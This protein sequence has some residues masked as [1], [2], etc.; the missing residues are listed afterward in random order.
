MKKILVVALTLIVCTGA[1]SQNDTIQ[2]PYL[3][4][5]VFPP[6]KL[7]LADSASYFTKDMLP[8]KKAIL[9]VVFNPECDHCQHETEEILKNID[10]FKDVQIVMSTNAEFRLMR[11]FI[12]HYN[13]N[14]YKNIVVGHDTNFFLITFFQMRNLPF[15]GFYNEK[16]ELISVFEGSMPVEKVLAELKK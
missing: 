3:K 10:Q 13:L 1:W 11:D 4:V 7:L 2:P 16:K 5:P 9:L 8:K 12:D 6:V 14:D 15:L